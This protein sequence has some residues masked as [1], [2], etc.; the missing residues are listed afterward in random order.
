M[1]AQ[2]VAF[3]VTVGKS[4]SAERQ[5][6]A[7]AA[8]AQRRARGDRDRPARSGYAQVA[9]TTARTTKCDV[10]TDRGYTVVKMKIGGAPLDGT[11]AAASRRC[12]E[13]DRQRRASL[14]VRRQRPLDPRPRY[15]DAK[16]LRDYP[17]F[18]YEETGDPLDYAPRAAMAAFYPGADGDRRKPVLASG[19]AKSAALRRHA[20]GPRLAAVRLRAVLRARRGTTHAG[21][22]NSAA[23]RRPAAFR[24][25]ATRC[26]S[27]SPRGS[28][29]AAT[30]PDLFRRM[31]EF[32]DSVRVETG[33]IVMPDIPGIGFEGKTDL[34]SVMRELAE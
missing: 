8:G 23:G 6:Q 30:N 17:L 7:P 9:K 25:A 34:I 15:V 29:L 11:I 3:S 32:P 12:T 16:M 26:R 31:A 20:A 27:T 28:G 33:H 2:A 14:A 4:E 24:T 22:V 18:W 1:G 19:R 10:E 5:R 21:G 13:R